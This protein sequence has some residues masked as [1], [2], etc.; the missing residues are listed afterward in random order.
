MTF[1]N[2]GSATVTGS[3]TPTDTGKYNS[4]SATMNVSV[5]KIEPLFTWANVSKTYGDTPFSVTA[6]TVTNSVAGTWTYSSANT[7]V[8]TLSSATATVVG[9]GTSTITATFTPTDT[10]NYVSGGTVAMTVTVSQVTPLFSW[11]NVSATYG[12]ANAA[13]TEPTVTNSISGSWSYA[14]ATTSVVAISRSDFDFGNSGTS[15]ITA[16]FTPTDTTNYVSGGTVAMTVTVSQVTPLF[17]WSNVSATYGDANATI[18]APSVTGSIA[19]SWSYVSADTSVATISGSDYDFGNAG[20]SVVTATFT[21]TDTTNYVSGGTVT[22]TI[23]VAT[24]DQAGLTV[25]SLTGTYGS[26]VS[27]AV[28]GGTTNGAVTYAVTGDGCS[29]SGATLSRTNAGDCSVIATMVGNSNYN[30]VSSLATTVTFA[31][32]SQSGIT[33]STTSGTYG[34]ALTLNVSGGTTAGS[35]TYVVTGV[36]CVQ[37]NGVLTKDAAGDCSITATMAGDDNYNAVSSSA[38]TVTFARVAITVTAD[39]KSKQYGTTDPALTYVITAGSLVIG[40][41]LTGSLDRV[42][43][44]SVNTYAI[45]QGTLA[46]SNYTITYVGADLTIT[47]R[48]ITVT[49]TA[50]TK[51]YGATDPTFEYSVTTGSLVSGGALSGALGRESGANV[52]SYAMTIGTL[53]NANYAITFVPANLTITQRPITVTAAAATK[54]YGASDPALTHSVTTGSL[55]VGDSL[56]GTLSRVTGENVGTYAILRGTVDNTN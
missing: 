53:A 19:G 21:P 16:T 28:S 42:S 17:S 1:G 20:T 7:S 54:E 29:A 10:T 51:Q 38:T 12:D 22:M 39:V 34:I 25:T 47:Q 48:P 15:V 23:S 13:I 41:S 44:E 24:A 2:F 55:V 6:P 36:G 56:T 30:A 27:L 9:A 43:G 4:I 37:S 50:T 49:A 35:V 33:V 52:G 31:K 8:A 18:T 46:N 40:D 14:S 3:F 32:A 26:S 45:G 11:S 5:G